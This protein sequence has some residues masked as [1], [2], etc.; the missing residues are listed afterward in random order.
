[1]NGKRRTDTP[2]RTNSKIIRL[3]TGMAE[4]RHC[5][6]AATEVRRRQ[7]A[8]LLEAVTCEA[9]NPEADPEQELSDR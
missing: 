2:T 8:R 1:M 3:I 4:H 7:T 5:P 6:L 9:G